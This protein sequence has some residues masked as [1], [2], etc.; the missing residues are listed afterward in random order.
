MNH[1]LYGFRSSTTEKRFFSNSPGVISQNFFDRPT[2]YCDGHWWLGKTVFY[3]Y[4]SQRAADTFQNNISPDLF[5]SNAISFWSFNNI[6]SAHIHNLH[7][8]T[9]HHTT[10][11][12]I[13][14]LKISCLW[15]QYISILFTM[16]H[17]ILFCKTANTS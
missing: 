2:E 3:F 16:D 8:R 1:A 17:K 11:Q 14:F 7:Q 12:V 13:K 15:H 5:C 9:I 4:Q 10:H 6:F